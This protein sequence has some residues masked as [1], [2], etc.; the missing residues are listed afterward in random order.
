MVLS[1]HTYSS[2][3]TEWRKL[4]AW[5]PG[6]LEFLTHLPLLKALFSS[7]QYFLSLSPCR[8]M[9]E[10]KVMD[11]RLHV[12]NSTRQW[13][14]MCTG[15]WDGIF[16]ACVQSLP[17]TG[18]SWEFTLDKYHEAGTVSKQEAQH[19]PSVS[20]VS[21]SICFCEHGLCEDCT[22]FLSLLEQGL[23]VRGV[24]EGKN[25]PKKPLPFGLLTKTREKTNCLSGVFY[26]FRPLSSS[27]S[28][29][30]QYIV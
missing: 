23:L 28:P 21:V 25:K 30:S 2:A 9:V 6:L 22:F 3:S 29:L 1:S 17:V 19:V 5:P 7:H 20:R 8:G 18:S 24:S 11:C 26:F 14:K 27:V 4:Y 13:G 12:Y 16:Q 10:G 15:S